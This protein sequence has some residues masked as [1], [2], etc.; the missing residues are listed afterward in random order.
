MKSGRQA[1]TLLAEPFLQLSFPVFPHRESLPGLVPKTQTS[2]VLDLCFFLQEIL[3][4]S[5]SEL[6]SGEESEE[7]LRSG[8]GRLGCQ[9]SAHGM[10]GV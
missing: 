7:F 3:S 5:S 8:S 9:A 6:S 2:P 1:N 4:S 10:S